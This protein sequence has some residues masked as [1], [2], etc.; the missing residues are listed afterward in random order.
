MSY[1]WGSGVALLAVAAVGCGGALT[2]GAGGAGGNGGD[3]VM[4]GGAGTSGAAGIA[5]GS[6]DAGPTGSPYDGDYVWGNVSIH[7]G[8][9]T[10]AP[11]NLV[12]QVSDP[13]AP[14]TVI[15]SATFPA[16]TKSSLNDGAYLKGH[17]GCGAGTVYQ[18]DIYSCAN[19]MFSSGTR[20]PG[21]LGITFIQPAITGNFLSADGVRCD[22]QGGS[23][24][25]NLP[26]PTSTLVA[27]TDAGPPRP[28][29]SGTFLLDCAQADGAHRLLEATFALPIDWQFLLC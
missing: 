15:S 28:A 1:A 25:F 12:L 26:S 9:T 24:T 8:P 29:G 2:G 10:T 23:A 14:G 21:C 7:V 17:I 13:A 3:G 4:T 16:A 6:Y 11:G 5:G 22:I 20:T 19:E 18:L 27:P